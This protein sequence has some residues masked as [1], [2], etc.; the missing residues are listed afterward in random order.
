MLV[1][2][3]MHKGGL[4]PEDFRRTASPS[5]VLALVKAKDALFADP[6]C[7]APM[8]E[9]EARFHL[10]CPGKTLPHRD[11]RELAVRGVDGRT[12]PWENRKDDDR[13]NAGLPRKI[14][15][16]GRQRL[17]PVRE[18][19]ES[20]S[21]FGLLDTVGNAGDW[22]EDEGVEVAE[23]EVRRI[24]F[25]GGVFQFN[26]EDCTAYSFLRLPNTEVDLLPAR[27]YWMITC[28]GVIPAR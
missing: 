15:W 27:G 4:A 5:D 6:D 20:V 26:A 25:T 7:P 11:H 13:I 24:G 21:P 17:R 19:P 23:D 14:G 22:V 28:R 16:Q 12:Y 10:K 3:L 2:H 9:R 1:W 18:H 8:T